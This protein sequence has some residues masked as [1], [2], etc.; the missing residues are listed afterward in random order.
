M[1]RRI[2]STSSVR[3]ASPRRRTHGDTVRPREVEH[4]AERTIGAHAVVELAPRD[5]LE[6]VRLDQARELGPLAFIASPV[7]LRERIRRRARREEDPRPQVCR[8]DGGSGSAALRASSRSPR[9]ARSRASTVSASGTRCAR[10][11]PPSSS[12]RT[13]WTSRG[14]RSRRPA[15]PPRAAE[16]TG[17]T[18]PRCRRGRPT[19]VRPRRSHAR[20]IRRGSARPAGSTP[21]PSARRAPITC[22]TRRQS[23]RSANSTASVPSSTARR[24]RPRDASSSA[25]WPSELST[26]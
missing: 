15:L 14:P 13:P 24:N 16:R 1:P 7:E 11:L 3:T 2:C 6:H 18:T 25:S 4:V 17:A 20:A 9:A 8:S 19:D 12:A 23:R 26:T 10:R 22:S 5:R 21:T